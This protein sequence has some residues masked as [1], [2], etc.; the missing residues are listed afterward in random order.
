MGSPSPTAMLLRQEGWISKLWLAG[1]SDSHTFFFSVSGNRNP[2][3]RLPSDTSLLTKLTTSTKKQQRA[4]DWANSSQTLQFLY[5]ISYP[6]GLI[7][8]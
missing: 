6:E 5:F 3:P 7:F 8:R 1:K 4:N 2:R